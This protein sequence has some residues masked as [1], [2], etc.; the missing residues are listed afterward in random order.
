MIPHLQDESIFHQNYIGP[1]E[2]YNY[3]VLAT[4]LW[5]FYRITQPFNR[6]SSRL[7]L[8]NELPLNI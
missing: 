7:P 4:A 1:A 5:Y 3:I 2:T 6:L 8:A